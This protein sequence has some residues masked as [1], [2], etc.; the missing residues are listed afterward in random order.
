M[1]QE[2]DPSGQ[3]ADGGDASPDGVAGISTESLTHA[4]EVEEAVEQGLRRPQIVVITGMSGAGR[5][6]VA[7]VLEDIEY[8][9][10]DNLPPALIPK[11]QDLA[12]GPGTDVERLALVADIRGRA[13]FGDLVEALRDLVAAGANV[14]IVFLEA[15]DDTLVTRFESSRRRHPAAGAGDGVLEG[16]VAERGMLSEIRGM[17]DLVVDTSD[18]NVHELRDRVIGLLG[19]DEFAQLRVKV[20]SFGFKHGSPRDADMVMDV[21]FLPNPHWVEDLRPHTG[22]DAPVRDYVFA[23]PETDPFVDAFEELLD[24]VVPGLCRGG[25][26]LPH[27]RHRLHGRA[28]PVRGHRRTRRQPP[29]GHDRSTRGGGAPGPGTVSV[30]TAP[31]HDDPDHNVV[32]IGGGHGLSRSLVALQLCGWRPTAIVSMADDGGSSGR[33]RQELHVGPPGDLRRALSSLCPDPVHR[34]LLEHRFEGGAL[35][36]HAAGNLVLLAGAAVQDD[37]LTAGLAMLAVLFDARGRVVP[38]CEQ[39]LDLEATLSD[40]SVVR[41][42][43]RL[44][45]TSGVDTVRLV[46][47]DVTA[48]PVGVAAIAAADLVVM[49]PGS[50]FTSLIPPLLTTEVARALTTT[51]ATR[52]VVANI[53]QQ[54]G[55]TEGMDLQGHVDALFAHLPDELFDRRP[56]LQRRSRRR[57]RP[58]RAPRPGRPGDPSAHRSGRPRTPDGR[59]GRP[60]CPTIGC[61]PAGGVSRATT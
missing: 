5:T 45:V 25:Q 10:V 30:A 13:F 41:G 61:R 3:T 23:Q 28:A 49:G 58:G 53:R 35:S 51:A 36:G 19:D 34:A 55:E 40:G 38:V 57:R 42:Q 6:T 2:R 31:S 15:D 59:E 8:F 22:L 24:V 56:G 18:L 48:N 27:H 9:V 17:A 26:A 21:R 20:V 44:T 43:R 16:I 52:V 14:R 33:L 60:R 37:D 47:A 7:K 1:T 32:A 54:P 29:A 11:V 4:R 46:P 39:G 50:L 12:F